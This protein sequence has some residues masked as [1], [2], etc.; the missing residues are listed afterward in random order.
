MAL[1]T[2]SPQPQALTNSSVHVWGGWVGVVQVKL[3]RK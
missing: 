2:R 1:C 3:T